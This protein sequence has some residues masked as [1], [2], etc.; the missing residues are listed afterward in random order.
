M[1]EKARE[2]HLHNKPSDRN[3]AG[4]ARDGVSAP[5]SE[6]NVAL[7]ARRVA[8]ATQGCRTCGRSASDVDSVSRNRSSLRSI[9][10]S[11]LAS[12]PAHEDVASPRRLPQRTVTPVALLR[13]APEP[14]RRRGAAPGSASPRAPAAARR[15]QSRTTTPTTRP[16]LDGEASR[17]RSF[18]ARARARVHG[19]LSDAR[20]SLGH[21][22]HGNEKGWVA[23]APKHIISSLARD[24]ARSSTHAFHANRA[25]RGGKFW[26]SSSQGSAEV[27]LAASD[28]QT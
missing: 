7:S 2:R 16:R 17:T 9:V 18:A 6:R 14:L 28:G 25:Q 3:V 27:T 22:R 11:A 4:S 1:A 21:R 26:S 8:P 19:R 23:A 10:V 12:E 24:A 13:A 5:K 15:H 20:P